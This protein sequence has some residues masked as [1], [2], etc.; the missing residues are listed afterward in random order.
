MEN[1]S[2]PKALTESEEYKDLTQKQIFN[3]EARFRY[4][5][6]IISNIDGWLSN[7]TEE[8]DFK[9]FLDD[10]ELDIGTNQNLDTGDEFISSW[11]IHNSW[12]FGIS[13]CLLKGKLSDSLI[14]ELEQ[15][16]PSVNSSRP[17]FENW[18]RNQGDL[19]KRIIGR[20]YSAETFSEVVAH[21]IALDILLAKFLA[22]LYKSRLN[23]F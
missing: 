4:L 15:E 6:E 12:T 18:L 10:L 2:L 22:G 16:S 19:L 3:F 8:K 11:V 20:F 17:E 14:K 5:E 1:R 13:A 9:S 23:D 21:Y 7:M